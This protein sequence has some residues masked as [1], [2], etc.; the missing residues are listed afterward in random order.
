[1]TRHY[2]HGISNFEKISSSSLN[3][4]YWGEGIK[5]WKNPYMGTWR[6]VVGRCPCGNEIFFLKIVAR[7]FGLRFSAQIFV[8]GILGTKF[9]KILFF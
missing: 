2:R 1:M 3:P 5:I 6:E 8:R 7:T 4:N 9:V